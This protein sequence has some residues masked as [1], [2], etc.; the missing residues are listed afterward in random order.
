MVVAQALLPPGMATTMQPAV[1]SSEVY[2]TC[3]WIP[4]QLLTL[5]S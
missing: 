2:M 1:A 5:G 3:L 4:A